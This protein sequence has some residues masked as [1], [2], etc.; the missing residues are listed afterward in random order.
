MHLDPN[1]CVLLLNAMESSGWIE[2]R[3]DP[4]DRRRHIVVLTTAGREALASAE[5]AMG[6]LEAE[7]LSTLEPSEREVLR[8]LLSRALAEDAV[9]V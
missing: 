4:A 9:T 1:N 3:R 2:R 6:G 8:D 7:V 5:H